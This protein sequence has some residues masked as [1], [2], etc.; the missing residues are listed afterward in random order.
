MGFLRCPAGM[1]SARILHMALWDDPAQ[2]F[3]R[4]A[5]GVFCWPAPYR[6]RVFGDDWLS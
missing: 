2:A 5:R 6:A 3:R 4:M 1:L